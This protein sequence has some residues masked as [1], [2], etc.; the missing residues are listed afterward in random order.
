MSS[1]TMKTTPFSCPWDSGQ[2]GFIYAKKAD[3][4]REFGWKRMSPQREDDIRQYLK[5]EV[6]TYDM[7]LRGEVYG[8]SIEG[9]DGEPIDSC[10]GFYGDDPFTNG[11][12]EHIDPELHPLLKEAQA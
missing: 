5:A 11:M 4:K 10:W 9:H 6:E 1:I 7:Y 12:A 8:F 3:L 2:V